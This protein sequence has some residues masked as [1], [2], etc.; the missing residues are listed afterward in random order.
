M[1]LCRKEERKIGEMRRAFHA[2]WT[3]EFASEFEQR[4]EELLEDPGGRSRGV[5][6]AVEKH[7]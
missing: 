2:W 4:L 6:A 1:K 5:K 7:Q 3:C